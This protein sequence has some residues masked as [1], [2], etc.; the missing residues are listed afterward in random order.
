MGTRREFLS[1][2]GLA[3]GAALWPSWLRGQEE[4]G[5]T[6]TVSL[7]HTTDL[8][9]HILPT[10][11]YD[12][13][14]DVGGLAR[15]ASQIRAWR[16]ESPH[17]LLF[18]IGDVYQ[19]TAAGWLT[20]G[21]LMIDLFNK[22][23][24]DGWV[25]GNHE[26]DWG[27]EVVLDALVRSTMPVLTGNLEL[28]GKMAGGWDDPAN[29]FSKILPHVVKD[30]GGVKIGVIGAIGAKVSQVVWVFLMQGMVVGLIGVTSGLT[31][32]L[33]VLHYREGFRSFIGWVTGFEILDPRVYGYAAV[34]IPAF[35]QA[36]DVAM[37][38][39]VSFL[40]CALAALVPAYFAARIDPAKALRNVGA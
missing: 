18:D 36:Y 14:A 3:G 33:L 1:K 12:G 22:L 28:G 4:S 30:V 25:L 24:Y 39:G 5:G 6:R 13:T 40:M 15:C 11:M 34:Q 29:P 10:R 21:R 16:K 38:C 35:T 27:P 17:S 2:A 32:G 31:M 8:H 9:G 19:G 7:F 23:G 37:I 20:R 26:F